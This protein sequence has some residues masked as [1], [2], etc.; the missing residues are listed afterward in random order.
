MVSA[1]HVRPLRGR[2]GII[3]FFFYKC[4]TPS[5]SVVV[6]VR[7][8]SNRVGS[9]LFFSYKLCDPFR[10]DSGRSIVII[11]IDLYYN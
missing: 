2:V 6:L 5:G 9:F 11:T 4:A 3:S 1:D 8:N 10:V 7:N